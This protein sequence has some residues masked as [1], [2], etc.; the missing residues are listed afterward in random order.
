MTLPIRTEV[1][2]NIDR[3]EFTTTYLGI[4]ILFIFFYD[5][6]GNTASFQGTF[7]CCDEGRKQCHAAGS[8]ILKYNEEKPAK[9][10]VESY[11]LCSSSSYLW[12]FTNP[13]LD[14]TPTAYQTLL[15]FAKQVQNTGCHH[16]T[17]A[18]SRFG[19]AEQAKLV[20]QLRVDC[21]L[22]CKRSYPQALLRAG[23]DLHLGQYRS[24]MAEKEDLIA[25][26][27]C[28]HNTVHFVSS[29]F[30]VAEGKES[31]HKERAK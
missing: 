24:H 19:S 13:F 30:S 12:L 9:W 26:A 16:H 17:T 25:A 20:K 10:V 5:K 2:G 21:T 18:D 15:L 3:I 14:N 27:Y 29:W 7:L 1:W 28:Q 4:R 6:H 11:T 31:G 23:L 22:A 8:T